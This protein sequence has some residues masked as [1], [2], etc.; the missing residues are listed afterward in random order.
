[1]FLLGSEMEKLNINNGA[2]EYSKMLSCVIVQYH[3][4]MKIDTYLYVL[5][6]SFD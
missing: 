2:F 4:L 3:S 5:N 1:M 6:Q